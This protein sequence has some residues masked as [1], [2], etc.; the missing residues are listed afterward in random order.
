MNG[1]PLLFVYGTLKRGRHNHGLLRQLGAEFVCEAQTSE[2]FPLVVEG[3]PY[4][5][6]QPGVGYHVNGEIFRLD[7]CGFSFVDRLEGHPDWYRRRQIDLTGED[8][9]Q[10]SAWAYFLLNPEGLELLPPVKRYQN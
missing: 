8:G 3:L 1:N 6:D 7:E 5:L 4:L 10:Y 9:E 2:R